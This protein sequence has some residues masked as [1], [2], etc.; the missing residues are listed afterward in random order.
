LY[1][2]ASGI[3][4]VFMPIPKVAGSPVVRR[5]L[6]EDIEK[7]TG[8]KFLFTNDVEV[9]AQGIVEHLNRKRQALKLSPMLHEAVSF[10]GD[11][12]ASRPAAV[13]E[14]PKGVVALGCGETQRRSQARP[15]VD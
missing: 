10:S 15:P 1:A 12:A 13:Y 8:G 14:E 6:E 9:A 11:L 3:F 7:E 2:V 5:Y 4:T